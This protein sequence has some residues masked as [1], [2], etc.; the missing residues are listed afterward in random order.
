MSF[1][2]CRHSS[3][4]IVIMSMTRSQDLAAEII[5][6]RQ[7]KRFCRSAIFVTYSL[8][9]FDSTIRTVRAASSSIQYIIFMIT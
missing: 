4:E 5:E 2:E 8:H 6:M 1:Q 9:N 3:S 7:E